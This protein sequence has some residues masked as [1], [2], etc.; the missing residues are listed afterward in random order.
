MGHVVKLTN[1]QRAAR[2]EITKD[3]WPKMNDSTQRYARAIVSMA[4][5]HDK[6]TEA[7]DDAHEN[8]ARGRLHVAAGL[9]AAAAEHTRALADQFDHAAAALL[10][11]PRNEHG[12]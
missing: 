8:Y 5:L 12:S 1:A 9:F 2:G 7:E 11:G 4:A 3:P 10:A 6:A